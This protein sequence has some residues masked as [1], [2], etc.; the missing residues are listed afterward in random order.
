MK[1]L[2][3][4]LMMLLVLLLANSALAI[5]NNNYK[6]VPVDGGYWCDD[7]TGRK[8]LEVL[9]TRREQLEELQSAYTT[10][11]RNYYDYISQSKKELDTLEK[12]FNDERKQWKAEVRKAYSPGLGIFAGP[13]Y[14]FNEEKIDFVV[15]IGLVWRLW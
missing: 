7:S 6:F 11:E 10:L 13:A 15:G 2:V 1:L 14:G 9:R 5:Q 4:L 3:C 12:L 8:I